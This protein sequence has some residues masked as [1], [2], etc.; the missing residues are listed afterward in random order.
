[1]QRQAPTNCMDMPMFKSHH[2][3]GQAP[4]TL[5]HAAE[6]AQWVVVLL[7]WVWLGEQGTLLGWSM[8]SG[9]LPVALWWAV[10]LLCRAS[11]WMFRCH[12]IVLAFAGLLTVSGVWVL[13][14]LTSTFFSLTALLGLAMV[15]GAW[16][17]LIETR[18]QSSTFEL[19]SVAWHPVIAAV[20]VMGGWQMLGT[21]SVPHLGVIILLTLCAGLLYANDRYEAQ[22]KKTCLGVRTNIQTLLAPSAMGLMM[23]SLWLNNAWCIGLGWRTE[24]MVMTHLGLMAG[25]PALVAC[26]IRATNVQSVNQYHF[27]ISLA[28]LALGAMAL[29]GDNP[30]YSVLAMLLPSL[31]WSLHCT[32]SRLKNETTGIGSPWL[33]KGLALLV[34]PLL[35]AW[36]GVL[37]PTQGPLAI[38]TALALLGTLALLQLMHLWWRQQ[39]VNTHL[40]IS[41]KMEYLNHEQH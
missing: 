23:G 9:L 30:I 4:T 34:G 17:A 39:N 20:M 28:L 1:M 33:A 12:S 7:G 15:W 6:V 41:K 37:S 3:A 31:S 24:Q 21:T 19:G 13:G 25:L 40:L 8:A 14:R 26:V 5:T 35:L 27:H 16:S 38:Q 22:P 10:R 32:R 18:T 2:L 11:T 36:V 29:M